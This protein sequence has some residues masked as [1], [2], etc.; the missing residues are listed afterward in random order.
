MSVTEV[1]SAL[2]VA[3]G[4]LTSIYWVVFVA[5]KAIYHAR[6]IS[7]QDRPLDRMA[8]LC[9]CEKCKEVKNG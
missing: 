8:E 1:F 5:T 3:V 6:P 2:L 9:G 4:I 7:F